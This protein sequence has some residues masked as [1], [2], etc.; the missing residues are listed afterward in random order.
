MTNDPNHDMDGMLLAIAGVPLCL[1]IDGWAIAGWFMKDSLAFAIAA[2][3]LGGLS[4]SL[5]IRA[6]LRWGNRHDELMRQR[7]RFKNSPY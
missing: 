7:D 6:L 1:L 4:T 5:L 3:I 2:T